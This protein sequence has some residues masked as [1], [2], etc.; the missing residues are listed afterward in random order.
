MLSAW[1]KHQMVDIN[2]QAFPWPKIL[3]YTQNSLCIKNSI[4]HSEK[5]VFRIFLIL[6]L[7]VMED[8]ILYML[9]FECQQPNFMKIEI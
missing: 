7:E 3:R 4:F 2:I 1:G 5:H 9:S 6:K 8:L